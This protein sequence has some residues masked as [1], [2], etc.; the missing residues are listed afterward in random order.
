MEFLAA[1][2]GSIVGKIA[3]STIE[4]I[5][6]RFGYLF[7]FESNISNLKTQFQHLKDTKQDLQNTLDL[8]TRR[9][10]EIKQSVK[11]WLI[12]ADSISEMV[13]S[14]LSD[15]G[16]S[17]TGCSI[18]C[19]PNL[20]L[21]HRL[22]RRAKKMAQSVVEIKEAA[23]KFDKVS[24]VSIPQNIIE[25][26]G[27]MVFDTRNSIL[28]GIMEALRNNDIRM[29]GVWGM[30]GVG[31]TTLGKEVAKRALEAK[32]FNDA[33]E[34]A[35]SASPKLEKIQQDIA[36]R[37][38]LD[39]HAKG[40]Q[41]RALHLRHR[42]RTEEKFLIIL[43]DVWMKLDLLEIGICLEDDQK[44]CKILLTSRSQSVL[45]DDMG[46]DP[47]NNFKVELLSDSEAW[48]WFSKIV[49]DSVL[50]DENSDEFKDLATQIVDKCA[51]L[52]L[53]I[54]TVA[55]ALK[56][57]GIHHWKDALTR[58]QMSS[59]DEAIYTSVKLSFDILKKEE[60]RRILLFCSLYGEDEE[61][62]INELLDLC[63]G[64]GLFK[65][66][67]TLEKARNRLQTLLDELISH[68]LLLKSKDSVKM[69]D[70]IRDVGITIAASEDF[71]MYNIR[72][73]DELTEYLDDNNKLKDSI[74]ISLGPSYDDEC[75]PS[76][77]NCPELLL[78]LMKGREYSSLPD[79]F[80]EETKKLK[81]LYLYSL[82]LKP[83]PSSFCCLKNLQALHLVGAV[84][85]G[86]IHLIGELKKL[87]VLDLRRSKMKQLPEQIGQLTC[88]CKLDLSRCYNLQVVPPHV[89]SRL[90]NLEEL[91]MIESFRNWKAEGLVDDENRT[92]A[93]LSE[94][95]KLIKLTSLYL[96]IPHVNML[97]KDL[98]STK[99]ERYY[100]SLGDCYV[101]SMDGSRG[102]KL[103]LELE[104]SSL[105]KER[106][107]QMLLKRSE[108]LHI[109]KFNGLKNIVCELDKIG[110]LAHLKALKVHGNDKIQ[111]MIDCLSMETN[112]ISHDSVLPSLER[113][114][115]NT[116]DNLEEICHGQLRGAMSLGKLR[117]AEVV[118]CNK[119]KNLLPFS[120]A[121][122]LEEIKVWYCSMME[123][124]VTSERVKDAINSEAVDRIEF[125]N[126]KRMELD[127]L[128]QLTRFC[129]ECD[130][131]GTPDQGHTLFNQKVALPSLQVLDL[132]SLQLKRIWADQ[133][134][135]TC[136]LQNLRELSVRWCYSL[137]YLLSFA[138]A[139]SLVQLE[140]LVVYGC[141]GMKEIII[142]KEPTVTF[143]DS[144]ELE[145]MELPK[146]KRIRL[147][148]LPKLIQFCSQ[149]QGQGSKQLMFS[150]S[151]S[152]FFNQEV[153]FPSLE[154]L[155][156]RG[157]SRSMK[158]VWPNQL[159]VSS[160][161][162]TFDLEG[163]HSIKYV[164]PFAIAESLVQLKKLSVRK[165]LEVEVII[166]LKEPKEEV[167]K[168]DK[169][170][171]PNLEHVELR[172]LPNLARFCSIETNI[173]ALNFI[174]KVLITDC[175]KLWSP[176]D[177]K[178]EYFSGG[179]DMSSL[180]SVQQRVPYDLLVPNLTTKLTLYACNN[181]ENLLSASV[182]KSFVHLR[183]LQVS[184]CE[185]L[186]EVVFTEESGD[187]I[188]S[189]KIC[190]P[191][192]KI[193]RLSHLTNIEK[194]CAGDH[195]E[196]LF[197][198]SLEIKGCPKLSTFISRSTD[199]KAVPEETDMDSV[200]TQPAL[201]NNQK[202]TLPKLRIMVLERCNSIIEIWHVDD[203]KDRGQQSAR[204]RSAIFQSLEFLQVSECGSLNKLLEANSSV[205]FENL[206]DLKVL[207]C[208]RMEYLL[209]PSAAKTLVQLEKMGVSEC[210]AMKGIIAPSSSS[211]ADHDDDKL[212]IASFD[213]LEVL[214]LDSLPSLTSFHVGKCALEFP[215]LSPVVVAGNCPELR[216]FCG[217]GSTIT[218]PKLT[219]FVRKR[220]EPF[221]DLYT[222]I[223]D[224]DTQITIH[225]YWFKSLT[226]DL[227]TDD[228]IE[229]QEEGGS[230]DI[231]TTIQQFWENYHPQK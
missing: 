107:F 148:D 153:A 6:R 56:N 151:T 10:E 42:L 216:S 32:L 162:R 112:H 29:I 69:H 113:F 200:A 16:Q 30:P 13:E 60:A 55:H 38:G 84:E 9:G 11:N 67:H 118:S 28:K 161:L 76:R 117:K 163:C 95:K 80:F 65:H 211:E 1:I 18:K 158:R 194:F 86:D 220:T 172:D 109:N 4:P 227:E 131:S 61:I 79:N 81:I 27:Y 70:V 50:S 202:I 191:A 176:R 149:S 108:Y 58:L 97:P 167:E 45:E 103:N 125:P 143:D 88:L 206:T 19:F 217:H 139:R 92:N 229:L 39:F 207:K 54:I 205:S 77:L 171:L 110:G 37:L 156:L 72:S 174:R 94:I 78:L 203:T 199:H 185:L 26:K 85:L 136:Y 75:L 111:Y 101:Y 230:I 142:I 135:Q 132:K 221:R 214:V 33:V 15:E 96:E 62:S 138:M 35:V 169:K 90:V 219:T 17:N 20:V 224:T 188:R 181:V 104:T 48:T 41:A 44:G 225:D 209:S 36:D 164:L 212:F 66:V 226:L 155:S 154:Y 196:C 24:K 68:C 63:V 102:L 179:L 168:I 189:H 106:G 133:L 190:F 31:K 231:N 134:W 2:G 87:K 177:E 195:I 82:R 193:L 93:S 124:I 34:V 165:C 197:L 198:E 128:P 208:N 71:K 73:N 187:G 43:D 53:M 175:P 14:F 126:L 8:A 23:G 213:N 7:Y 223:E 51:C 222:W 173:C 210:E 145:I 129:A 157:L 183:T 147:D 121:K 180:N 160:N 127:H 140:E 74:A 89:I 184:D 119:L 83:L 137:K 25:T 115:F 186:K 152:A 40:V 178:V 114:S 100:I 166:M 21:R 215:K 91:K 146:L 130:T 192:L 170:L 123:E 150:D 3:K 57:K 201:F 159:L 98:F 22:S 5:G 52:P 49:G 218:T 228:K 144:D 12:Q 47:G 64:W 120:I 59:V 99:L 182:T 105:L 46:V 204:S 141:K 122:R 116:V